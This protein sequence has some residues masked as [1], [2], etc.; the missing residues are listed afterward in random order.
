MREFKK[1]RGQKGDVIHLALRGAGC[2]VLFGLTALAVHSAWGMYTK[3][4]EAAQG[5]ES[6]EAQLATLAEQEA[7]V[8]ASVGDISSPRGVEAQM[9]ERFGAAR[10]G[11]G[12]IQIVRDAPSTTASVSADAPWWQRLWHTLFVW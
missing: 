12:V 4:A 1:R 7:Q 10:P 6:A 9:R 5:R 3:L 2:L 11:E 8:R